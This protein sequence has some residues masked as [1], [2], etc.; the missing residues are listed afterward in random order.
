MIPNRANYG[1][2]TRR[3]SKIHWQKGRS[4][5]TGQLSGDRYLGPVQ[6][7][8]LRGPFQVAKISR[9]AR[10]ESWPAWVSGAGLASHS[11]PTTPCKAAVHG[12]TGAR[13]GPIQL[14]K[15]AKGPQRLAEG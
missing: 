1:G 4:T 9:T 7:S 13:T 12:P 3:T 5:V 6:V 11:G 14:T 2:E 15:R 10:Q 8:D